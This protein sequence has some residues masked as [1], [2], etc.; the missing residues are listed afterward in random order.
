MLAFGIARSTPWTQARKEGA[1]VYSDLG[2]QVQGQVVHRPR[3]D[4]PISGTRT[5]S[6]IRDFSHTEHLI[7]AGQPIYNKVHIKSLEAIR[8]SGVILRCLPPATS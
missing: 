8:V 5:I 6:A 7:S 1:L 4:V 3:R 2:V